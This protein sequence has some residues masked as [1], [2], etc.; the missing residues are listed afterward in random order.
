MDFRCLPAYLFCLRIP[1]SEVP[2]DDPAIIREVDRGVIWHG[3]QAVWTFGVPGQ[4]PG[5]TP[6]TVKLVSDPV[7]TRLKRFRRHALRLEYNMVEIVMRPVPVENPVFH[8]RE[9]RCPRQ[10]SEDGGLN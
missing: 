2:S 3:C 7:V 10:G 1:A 8:G 6:G 4:T 9:L 5:D